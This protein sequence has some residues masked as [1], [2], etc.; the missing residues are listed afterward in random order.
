M[1]N[2][3]RFSGHAKPQSGW[4]GLSD[5]LRSFALFRPGSGTTH[6]A[7]DPADA[8]RIVRD[9][10]AAYGAGL[11]LKPELIALTKADL[12]DAKR[13]QK[14]ARALERRKPERVPTSEPA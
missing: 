12:L 2:I 10:L 5:S 1:Y 14:V 7:G 9:E 4:T 3:R 13:L 8:Y 11:E 6:A